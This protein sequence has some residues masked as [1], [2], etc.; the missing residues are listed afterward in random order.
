MAK[1]DFWPYLSS[2]SLCL[3]DISQMCH[4]CGKEMPKNLKMAIFHLIGQIRLKKGS[5]NIKAYQI[6]KSVD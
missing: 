1:L 4:S 3:A 6:W 2:K 5:K